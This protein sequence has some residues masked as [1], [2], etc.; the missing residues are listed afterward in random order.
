VKIFAYEIGRYLTNLKQ[1]IIRFEE[2]EQVTEE[3]IIALT[4][5]ITRQM[6]NLEIFELGLSGSPQ[7]QNLTVKR[8]NDEICNHLKK[9]TSFTLDLR[10]SEFFGIFPLKNSRC[11]NIGDKALEILPTQILK[12]MNNLNILKLKFGSPFISD[13]GLSSLTK[14][15]FNNLKGINHLELRFWKCFI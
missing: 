11:H 9:L 2:C 15:L 14:I 6:P 7:L 13:E 10:R 1:L 3:G 12:K 8:I 5:K 4:C